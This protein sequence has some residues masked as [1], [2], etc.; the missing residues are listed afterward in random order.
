MV[1]SSG[2][3]IPDPAGNVLTTYVHAASV[4]GTQDNVAYYSSYGGRVDISAPRGARKPG[5]PKFDTRPGADVLY[6][7]WSQLGAT[8]KTG[9]ICGTTGGLADFACS[10]YDG[11]T[12]G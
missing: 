10:D 9:D 1:S 5:V 3:A 7:G 12:F 11:A 8:V 2:N 4:V 6:G